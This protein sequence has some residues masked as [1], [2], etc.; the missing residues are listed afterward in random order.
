M[1]EKQFYVYILASSPG[2]A[3]Y[4]GVT[5]DLPK[6]IYQHREGM[7]EGFTKKYSIKTLVHYEQHET[8]ESAILREKRLKKWTRAMKNDLIAQSNP[9]WQDLYPSIAA[10]A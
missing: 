6:R 9:H 7:A 3:I 4:I 1:R 10:A 8:A 5:S 2:G